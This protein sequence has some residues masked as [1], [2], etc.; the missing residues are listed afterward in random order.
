MEE[1]TKF[2]LD[3]KWGHDYNSYLRLGG[4]RWMPGDL[5]FYINMCFIEDE[6]LGSTGSSTVSPK[7]RAVE[8]YTFYIYNICE[9]FSGFEDDPDYTCQ[10]G[11]GKL[12]QG[13]EL[14]PIE[15]MLLKDHEFWVKKPDGSY[16]TY[17]DPLE[18]L[19]RTF[20]RPLGAPLYNNEHMDLLELASR[21]VG[22]SFR[23]AGKKTHKFTFHGYKTY[24]A[25]SQARAEKNLTPTTMV[26][27]AALTGKSA[28]TL[29]KFE[30][31]YGFLKT[32][33]GTYS[34][35]EKVY[36]G[37]FWHPHIGTLKPN[38]AENPFSNKIKNRA[39]DGKIGVGSR[40]IHV[41]YTTQNP[42]AGVGY[43]SQYM[44]VEEV[45]LLAN[46][47]RVRG[48]NYASQ[49]RKTKMGWS[50]FIGT[51]GNMDKIKEV[52]DAYLNPEANSLYAI[53]DVF[54]RS[55][56]KVG[57]F[58]PAYYRN[59]LFIDENGNQNLEL[60]LKQEYI[61][62]EQKLLDR[63]ENAYEDHIMSYPLEVKEIFTQT[64]FNRFPVKGLK[65]LLIELEDELWAKTAKIGYLEYEDNN[66][67][68]VSWKPDLY[69][70]LK[71]IIHIGDEFE[72]KDLSGAIVIYEHPEVEKMPDPTFKDP[73]YRVVYDPVDLEGEGTSLASVLVYK[74]MDEWKPEAM[75]NTIVAEW[76]GRY[77][78]MEDIHEIAFKLACYYNAKIYPEMNIEDFVRYARQTN[79]YSM[80]QPKFKLDGTI[81][82]KKNYEVGLYISPGMKPALEKW[83][84]EWLNTVIDKEKVTQESGYVTERALKRVYQNLRS[85]RLVEELIHY[86]RDENADHVSS[87]MLL[88][89]W[90]RMEEA[91]VNTGKKEKPKRNDD[92]RDYV[93]RL[94]STEPN[95]AFNY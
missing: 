25:F 34:D 61:E 57:L 26:I 46:F 69:N 53:P 1:Q 48:A 66:K 72:R 79:R 81:D 92:L 24:K 8:W 78:M 89:T 67:T 39:G 40:I 16:K 77:D 7:L 90:L 2:S 3:G 18:Y 43:R 59:S 95:P 73:L 28:E 41:T 63:K 17:V 94:Q 6:V 12:Q 45:G 23:V 33:V 55:N 11:V 65:E 42:E 84:E 21:G 62:R 29:D 19:K 13:I 64:G 54:S 36:P 68:K 49:K 37:F 20:D 91:K 75:K 60:A 32:K 51:G 56:K 15:E 38:N 76:I 14:T 88:A 93:K 74:G 86:R 35:G 47:S 82:Q 83:A 80:L 87:L 85:I 4:Y 22:K 50:H 52:K 71:P 70:K 10:L 5:Y 58:I 44:P 30:K 27:G 9:G 31:M